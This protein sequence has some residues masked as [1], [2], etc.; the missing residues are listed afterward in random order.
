MLESANLV[1][2]L[3]TAQPEAS[4]QFYGET[5]GLL[6]MGEDEHTIIFDSNGI[7]LRIQK[8]K[9]VSPAVGTSLGWEVDHIVRAV[10]DLA[11]KGILFV[12]FPGL[13]QDRD[14]IWTSPDGT[15]VAWFKDPDG[16]VLSLTE[17]TSPG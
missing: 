2:F 9:S 1:A 14:A 17:H 13:P 4:R 8:L 6:L 10:H 3:G 12:R 15:L 5:L 11:A 16:N 7:V